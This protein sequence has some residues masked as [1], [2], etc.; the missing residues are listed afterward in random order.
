MKKPNHLKLVSDK[1]KRTLPQPL[2][3]LPAPSD[4]AA[5]PSDIEVDFFMNVTKKQP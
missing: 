4:P 5:V 2:P 3:P 1:G